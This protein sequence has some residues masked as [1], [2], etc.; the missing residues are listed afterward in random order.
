MADGT[1]IK[2][3]EVPLHEEGSA[4]RERHQDYK[5]SSSA[6][7]GGNDNI[8]NGHFTS[9][10]WRKRDELADLYHYVYVTTAT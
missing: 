10:S 8:T 5:C 2:A 3:G 6:P 7:E 1:T 9:E 4:L